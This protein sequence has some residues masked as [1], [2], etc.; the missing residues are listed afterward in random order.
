MAPMLDLYGDCGQAGSE[1]LCVRL[2]VR[3][4]GGRN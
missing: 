3:G 1:C 2:G 4:G